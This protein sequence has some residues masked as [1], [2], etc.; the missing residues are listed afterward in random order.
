MSVFLRSAYNYDTDKVSLETGLECDPD[1]NRTQQQFAEEAD[2]NTI[3]ARFGLTGELPDVVRV[4]Q[5]GDFTGVS[6]F[7]S[8]MQAVRAAE[9]GFMELPAALR[10]R[11]QNDPQRLLEFME[12]DRNKDEAIKLGLV[13]KAP[14]VSRET[15][16]V[17]N[18]T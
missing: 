7:Q 10:A 14:E 12:D 8:A 13:N 9:E 6:D 18:P 15:P 11:F 17:V 4:P 16:G 5:S 3:V 1:D 2:I